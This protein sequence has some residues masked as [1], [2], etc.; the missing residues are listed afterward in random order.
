LAD[1]ACDESDSSSKDTIADAATVLLPPLTAAEGLTEK[2]VAILVTPAVENKGALLTG[3]EAKRDCVPTDDNKERDADV[4][5]GEIE[6]DP[7]VSK[8]EVGT[9]TEATKETY[10]ETGT[11]NSSEAPLSTFTADITCEFS[12]LL[13]NDPPILEI[14]ATDETKAGENPAPEK[15]WYSMDTV[16]LILCTAKETLD[17]ARLRSTEY[18]KDKLA[19]GMEGPRSLRLARDVC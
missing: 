6:A 16:E 18:E 2:S 17:N 7:D 3:T 15:D 12:A 8:L 11:D 14:P 10:R 13:N 4:T 19:V 1:I 9:A 5:D